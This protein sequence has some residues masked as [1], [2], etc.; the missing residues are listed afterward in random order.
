MEQVRAMGWRLQPCSLPTSR[1]LTWAPRACEQVFAEARV[2]VA[3]R[4]TVA[5]TE[6]L[7]G[8]CENCTHGVT[9][10]PFSAAARPQ[11]GPLRQPVAAP[12]LTRAQLRRHVIA[13]ALT[14][15]PAAASSDAAHAPAGARYA[16]HAR[17]APSA[18]AT[19]RPKRAMSENRTAA[20]TA[21]RGRAAAVADVT[22]RT[23]NCP[24]PPC[25]DRGGSSPEPVIPPRTSGP[26]HH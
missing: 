7:H 24:R 21:S 9:R 25:P 3:S 10:S 14:A 8:V 15:A 17:V 23:V 4:L 6:V 19:L 26:R 5:V 12:I 11:C 20:V 13:R 16:L 22:A 18:C 1:A 2:P